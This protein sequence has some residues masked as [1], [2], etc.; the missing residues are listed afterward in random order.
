[1]LI[2]SRAR[3]RLRHVDPLLAACCLVALVVYLLHG[4]DGMLS[5]D[6]G[7]YAY[8]GQQVAEGVPPYV[9]IANRVGPLAH[10]LPGGAA[11]VARVVGVDDLWAMRVFFMLMA[12]A[13][14]GLAYLVGRDVFRS[15]FAGVASAAALLSFHG[16][17]ELATY[18]PREKTPMVLFMLASFLA[19]AHQRWLTTG[20]LVSLA[21]LTWQPSF[22]PLIVTAL[23]AV[24]LGLPLRAWWQALARVTVGG[25]VPLAVTIG[26]YAAIDRLQMFLDCFVLVNVKY[27]S[28]LRRTVLDDPGYAWRLLDRNYGASV[29]VIFAGLAALL[30]AAAAAA[31]RRGDREPPT[32]ALVGCGVGAL[33]GIG[34]TFQAFDGWPDAFPVFPFAAVG[35]GSL[36]QFVVDRAP[37]K[38]ALASTLAV[39]TACTAIAVGFSVGKRDDRLV[40]Q[41][42]STDTVMRELPEA[43]ILSVRAPQS[44]VLTHQRQGSRFQ[45]F[46]HGMTQHINDTFPGG[47]RGYRLWVSQRAP[48]VI[49][50]FGTMPRWLA[51]E[52]QR[53]YVKVGKA[54]GW[55]WYVRRDVGAEAIAALRAGVTRSSTGG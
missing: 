17:I 46:A 52:V 5:T 48:T 19:I 8:A 4:F 22:F 20:V 34:W 9:A 23:V 51:P 44:L 54:P 6:Q 42:R 37:G 18:G 40:D 53:N 45:L 10:L 14:I 29:W 33:I 41:R 12:V 36:V 49:A 3:E 15:R 7:V 21:T 39:A 13:G 32:A 24:L 26:S 16:F 27:T 28:Q 31:L 25:L 47:I 35:I 43:Q 2:V 55:T 11:A 50:L 30:V 38:V 1:V